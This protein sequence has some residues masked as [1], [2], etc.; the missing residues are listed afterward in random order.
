VSANLDLVRSIFADFERGDFSSSEW[1]DPDIEYVVLGGLEP[2]TWTG[3]TDMARRVRTALGAWKDVRLEAD[4]YCEVDDQRV[5]VFNHRSGR[6][7]MSGFE[8]GRLTGVEAH[9]FHIRDG[10]VRKIVVYVD[11]DRALADLGLED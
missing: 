10:K 7:T 9:V 1:A 5:L 3:L 2:G 4:E 11:R 8:G 6:G